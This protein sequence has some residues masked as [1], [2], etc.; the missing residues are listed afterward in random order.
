MIES[1]FAQYAEQ[2]LASSGV[3]ILDIAMARKLRP[4][5]WP[6]RGFGC[7]R[8]GDNQAAMDALRPQ[9][10]ADGTLY[11]VTLR[12]GPDESRGISLVNGVAHRRSPEDRQTVEV[13]ALSGSRLKERLGWLG[14]SV[15]S[16]APW[17]A[18][19]PVPEPTAEEIAAREAQQQ[20]QRRK[21]GMYP[22][23]PERKLAEV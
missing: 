16:V 4:L 22:G 15:E 3:A 9:A 5:L 11:V 17:T 21:M 2:A 1:P 23:H 19:E 14:L 10:Q 18:P 7:V 12:P 13:I 20:E 8:G 6:D